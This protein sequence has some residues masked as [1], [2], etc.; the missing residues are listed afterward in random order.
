MLNNAY[1]GIDLG[2][3]GCRAYAIDDQSRIIAR[4]HKP[5]SNSSQTQHN[6]ALD[7]QLVVSVLSNLIHQCSGYKIQS[8][9]VDATSGSILVV[10]EKGQ[11]LTPILMYNNCN[12]RQQ[13]MLLESIV[14]ATSAAHGTGSGLAKLLYL[15][16]S[17]ALTGKYFLLHQADWINYNLGAP[18]AI[19]DENNALKSGYDPIDRCWPNWIGD[20]V[21]TSILPQVVACGTEI[22]FVSDALMQQFELSHRPTIKAGTTDSIAAFI[23]TGANELGD[24]LTSLGSTLVVKMLCDHPVFIPQQGVYSHRLNDR[25]LVGG[26]S[27][28]GGAVLKHYF[29]NNELLELSVQIDINQTVPDYYPLLEK[30]ERFPINDPDLQ[31]CLSPRLESR[32]EFLHALLN[33]IANVEYQSYTL[34]ER[35]TRTPIKS[36]RTVGTGSVNR[37]W[38]A[39]RQRKFHVSFIT[40]EN[41]E[42]AYGAALIAK[43]SEPNAK[44]I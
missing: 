18:L 6:P 19:S 30:G 22:G 36:I 27:N 43:D 25:W 14:P 4:C 2:T 37:T 1:I 41:T 44:L 3:S 29:T 5:F 39:I 16:E 17:Y 7:W 34:L 40:P 20:V 12:A 9:A 33:G 42:A 21:S 10:N 11:P 28:T 26:A 31:P 38:Q 23:A 8:I 24:A 35:I 32:S 13:A 15:I